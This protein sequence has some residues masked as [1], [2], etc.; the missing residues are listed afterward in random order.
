MLFCQ[1]YTQHLLTTEQQRS[2]TRE[3]ATK[4]TK[5]G[6]D[7]HKGDQRYP[8]WGLNQTTLTN[9]LVGPIQFT[10]FLQF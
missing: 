8:Q 7:V 10:H 1:P 3:L 5:E 2:L 9:T 4:E 6:T